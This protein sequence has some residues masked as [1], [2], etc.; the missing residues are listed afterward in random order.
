ML[1]GFSIYHSGHMKKLEGEEKGWRVGR[2]PF[3][4]SDWWFILCHSSSFQISKGGVG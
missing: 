1:Q 3:S 2:S 4:P